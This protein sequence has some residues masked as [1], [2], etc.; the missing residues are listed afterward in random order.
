MGKVERDGAAKARGD[1][2]GQVVV[3]VTGR[4]TR[5]VR[6]GRHRS[7]EVLEGDGIAVIAA[8]SSA[9][10]AGVAYRRQA[11]A[12]VDANAVGVV[13][14]FGGGLPDDGADVDELRRRGAGPR[15]EGD[16]VRPRRKRAVIDAA[17][18]HAAFDDGRVRAVGRSGD[19]DAFGGKADIE[20]AADD[21]S[22]VDEAEVVVEDADDL[23]DVVVVIVVQRVRDAFADKAEPKLVARR[24]VERLDQ[25]RG[26]RADGRDR[27]GGAV[28]VEV[29]DD[30]L[31]G[32][33]RVRAADGVAVDQEATP[34][35]AA[36]LDGRAADEQVVSVAAGRDR[37]VVWSK[38]V[39]VGVVRDSCAGETGGLYR[40]VDQEFA[41][42]IAEDADAG[43]VFALR[44]G[45]GA[46]AADRDVA[47]DVLAELD[48][49]AVGAG[50][51]DVASL[52]V[53][54]VEDGLDADAGGVVALDV[55]RRAGAETDVAVERAAG[56]DEEAG[57]AV[58]EGE[59]AVEVAVV[60][61]VGAG[62][63]FGVVDL[64][65]RRCSRR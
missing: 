15:S 57:A 53:V 56:V 50:D 24:A 12:G 47:G 38:R 33:G 22:T 40:A 31:D 9:D 21:R 26:R 63:V 37:R 5:A 13:G 65:R 1:V 3:A 60:V 64:R 18:E 34:E 54:A 19:P 7:R 61:G 42:D 11:C 45:G 10:Q 20:A 58:A 36:N 30:V 17:V 52:R 43:G 14:G 29:L 55:D 51:G 8:D 2:V 4:D 27:A 23:G 16:R 28:L 48:P 49:D 46:G 6:E 25:D 32:V 62:V 39:R 41:G 59:R 44:E 35:V